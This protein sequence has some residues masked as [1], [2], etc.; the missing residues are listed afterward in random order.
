MP[1][2][3][4]CYAP[5]FQAWYALTKP[6]RRFAPWWVL[7]LWLGWLL[8]HSTWWVASFGQGSG[9][10]FWVLEDSCKWSSLS[11]C[12]FSSSKWAQPTC[13]LFVI[14]FSFSRQGLVVDDGYVSFVSSWNILPSILEC[15]DLQA[16]LLRSMSWQ[17]WGECRTYT[18]L[19]VPTRVWC[20]NHP[21]GNYVWMKGQGNHPLSFSMSQCTI[22]SS[23]IP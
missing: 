5:C 2:I 16:N 6:R 23:W 3:A 22:T 8:A 4:I 14:V 19:L 15:A 20:I 7:L 10:L 1:L 13:S 9:V 12:F 18:P 21:Q 17:L 11:L